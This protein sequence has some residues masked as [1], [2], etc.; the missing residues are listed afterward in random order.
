MPTIRW[1]NL[2]DG[3]GLHLRAFTGRSQAVQIQAEQNGSGP[4]YSQ[5]TGAK[6]S[7]HRKNRSSRQF[8]L[9]TWAPL[10]RLSEIGRRQNWFRVP[11]KTG[12][13]YGIQASSN[14]LACKSS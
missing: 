13:S 11:G 9:E 12:A 7:H 14:E 10:L 4:Q 5:R 1:K 6:T 3:H 8:H 2:R